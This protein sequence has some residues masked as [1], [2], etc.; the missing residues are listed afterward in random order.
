M[1][2]VIVGHKIELKP[3]MQAEIYFEK[4]CGINRM[5]YNWGKA[6]WEELYEQ[7][8]TLPKEKRTKISGW[9]LRKEFNS[10][11]KEQFPFVYEV[12]KYACQQPFDDL[13]IAYKRFFNGISKKPKFK[14]KHKTGVV[15]PFLEKAN[16]LNSLSTVKCAFVEERRNQ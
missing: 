7:N 4:A 5:A 1:E 14:K 12:T 16:C 8:K 6:R 15:H 9:N 11:K 10:I 2:K 3:N 13:E